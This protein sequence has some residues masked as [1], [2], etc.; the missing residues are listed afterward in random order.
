MRSRQLIHK[1]KNMRVYRCD[2]CGF[3]HLTNYGA[4]ATRRIREWRAR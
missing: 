3:F 2:Q 4:N 1:K